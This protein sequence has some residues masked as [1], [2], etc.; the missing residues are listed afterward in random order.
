MVGSHFMWCRFDRLLQGFIMAQAINDGAYV[1]EGYC[2]SC[3]S[4]DRILH[5]VVNDSI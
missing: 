2:V 3:I 1:A 4:S 5:Y